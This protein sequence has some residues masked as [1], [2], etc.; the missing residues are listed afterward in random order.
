[1]VNTECDNRAISYEQVEEDDIGYDIEVDVLTDNNDDH[2]FEELEVDVDV[3]KVIEV[4]VV[5]ERYATIVPFVEE[6]YTLIDVP[7]G[8]D[9]YVPHG[10]IPIML[11]SQLII[12][13]TSNDDSQRT[14]YDSY[15]LELA[16]VLQRRQLNRVELTKSHKSMIY[17]LGKYI[18][19]RECYN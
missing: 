1:M 9:N 5:L 12:H 11:D 16:V 13:C 6:G 4:P 7:I 17:R 18:T 10:S 8:F 15:H 14:S 3:N 19:I 2:H